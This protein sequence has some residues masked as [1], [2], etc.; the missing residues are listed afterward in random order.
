MSTG[1][2]QKSWRAMK[3]AAVRK[4]GRPGAQHDS[5]PARPAGWWTQ[6]DIDYARDFLARQSGAPAGCL[7]RQTPPGGLRS[8]TL[9]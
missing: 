1:P 5:G 2:E 9:P 4:G 7:M 3:R 6:A 8:A